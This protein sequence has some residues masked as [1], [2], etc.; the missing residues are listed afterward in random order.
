[1]QKTLKWNGKN[2][3]DI[4]TWNV[5]DVEKNQRSYNSQMMCNIDNIT[6]STYKLNQH[7]RHKSKSGLWFY[8]DSKDEI[9]LGI[10]RI[11]H[12]I[13]T[14][15]GIVDYIYDPS[16]FPL[17]KSINRICDKSDNNIGDKSNNIN[18]KSSTSDELIESKSNESKNNESTEQNN[19]YDKSIDTIINLLLEFKVNNSA[20][21]L[22]RIKKDVSQLER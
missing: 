20:E 15:N 22:A 12:T 4:M 19:I 9:P 10:I 7:K 2:V 18:S 17:I 8:V 1:M 13:N 16:W 11:L 5:L 21:I 3:V 14:K 6:M